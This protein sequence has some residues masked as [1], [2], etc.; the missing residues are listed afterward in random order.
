MLGFGTELNDYWRSLIRILYPANCVLC[1]TSLVLEETYLCATCSQKIE[2]LKAPTCIRCAHPIPPYRSQRSTCSQCRLERPYY[3]QGFALVP[4]QEPI[5]DIFHQV[6]FQKKLWLLKIFFD[7][8]Q[9]T[10]FPQIENYEMIVPVPLDSK[11]ERERNFNQALVIAQMLKRSN[12]KNAPQ[13]LNIIQ[14][15]KKTL[16]QS[17]LKRDERLNNLEGAF[18]IKKN[19]MVRGKQ[20]LLVDDIV[21]T[22]ST[23]NE[24]AKVLKENGAER[25]DFFAVAR[26]QFPS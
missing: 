18:S 21:T 3:D 8:L 13:I 11:R 12:Q 10:T 5:K 1:R 6:K 19:G 16:P 26:S 23:I 4:Y 24:C 20:V 9:A 17:Q 14:K 7:R 15:K 22:G 2:P 25:V